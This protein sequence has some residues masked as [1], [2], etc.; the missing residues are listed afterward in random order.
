[1]LTALVDGREMEVLDFSLNYKE[2]K[3]PDFKVTISS[4]H[5]PDRS[6]QL[7]LLFEPISI[8][9]NNTVLISGIIAEYPDPDVINNSFSFLKLTCDNGLGYLYLEEAAPLQ[10]QDVSVSTAIGQLL[11]TTEDTT[12][13]LN[14]TTTLT[15]DDIT[16]DVRNRETL[17]AQLEMIRSSAKTPF[18]FRYA[19]E[20]GGIHQLD[21]GSFK[22]QSR[23]AFAMKD[24]NVTNSPKYSQ[25]NH[26]PILSIRP[27]SGKVNGKPVK[28]SD[29][30]N[31]DA[32]LSSD[33]DY[34]LNATLERVEN[35]TIT[36]GRRLRRAYTEI[37]TANDD[38]V[39]QDAINQVALAL[40]RR[41][42]RDMEA[43]ATYEVV[44][45][46]VALAAPPSIYDQIYCDV[47]AVQE[48]YDELK[49][50]M[51]QSD[52]VRIQGWY[53]IMTWSMKGDDYAQEQHPVTDEF[54]GLQ[55]YRLE[56]SNGVEIE[57]YDASALLID[58]VRSNDQE[59]NEGLISGSFGSI[60]VTVNHNNVA[61]DCDYNGLNTGKEFEF[62]LPDIPTGATGVT[63]SVR[64]TDPDTVDFNTSQVASL[65]QNLILCV[66]GPSM[67]NWTISDD[68]TIEVI[69][70]F[71]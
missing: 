7:A 26:L 51:V 19:G 66:S 9:Q 11:A 24:R 71:T 18:Y 49:Q 57:E 46:D 42:R 65:T 54:R 17:W 70:T 61:P 27:I 32:T 31:I 64:S 4:S 21:I 15:D 59:D 48:I 33:A 28:L 1:M 69:F 29:A 63:T 13:A 67:A 5:F 39:S 40:Y 34:P 58:S 52:A 22:E 12:W 8:M 16:V 6:E 23:T 60:L 44:R 25:P 55:I 35:D 50:Q 36:S 14:D 53:T 30:L 20:S 2:T 45:L 41:T 37:K 62:A 38:I 47:F 56:L 10:F 68:V 43:S 3:I